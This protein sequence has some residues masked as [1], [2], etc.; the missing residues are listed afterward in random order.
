MLTKQE[1]DL[2]KAIT[3]NDLEPL[4]TWL[5]AGGSPDAQNENGKSIIE[6]LAIQHNLEGIKI[7]SPYNP[8]I[9][10]KRNNIGEYSEN[11]YSLVK[12]GNKELKNFVELEIGFYE[13]DFDMAKGALSMYPSQQPNARL[14][15]KYENPAYKQI[16]EFGKLKLESLNKYNGTVAR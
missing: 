11:I 4:K 7:L 3:N 14:A 6:L 13:E 12:D 16:A 2:F 1:Q 15:R 8:D 10:V 9:S 5:A